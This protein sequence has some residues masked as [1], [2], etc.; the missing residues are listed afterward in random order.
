[1]K[2]IKLIVK[3]V[4]SFGALYYV[5]YKINL[6][7]VL[8]VFSNILWG[9]LILAIIFFFLSKLLAAER[10]NLLFKTIGIFINSISN[11]KLY[12][13]GMF[14]NLFLPGG[15]GGDGYKLYV[16]NRN[17]EVK[18]KRIFWTLLFDRLF[19]I[20][21]LALLVICLSYLI[22]STFQINYY[23]WMLIILIPI[24]VYIGIKIFY[25]YLKSAV[26]MS[27]L[28]SLGVQILQL[29]SCYFII[30]SIRIEDTYF[31]YMFLFLLS[32]IVAALPI[33]IGGMGAREIT[34]LYGAQY[35]LLNEALA[36]SISFIFYLITAFVSFW[37]IA[38]S[39]NINRYIKP[40]TIT[41]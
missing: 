37:G 36:I 12:L 21:A 18:G 23:Q 32:S 41:S 24:A 19:G 40:Q 33:S 17:S 10:L 30:K 35:L 16:L 7:E 22:E 13:M 15:I 28:L 27:I 3:I 34:F 39:F 25:P 20:T 4:I 14:Y 29:V 2:Y 1:M 38:F 9:Y 26:T 11:Y 5:L 31:T 6:S 8:E